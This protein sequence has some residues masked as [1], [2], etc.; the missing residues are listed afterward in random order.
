MNNLI[1]LKGKTGT[2]LSIFFVLALMLLPAQ[3]VAQSSGKLSGTATDAN[4]AAVHKANVVIT[5]QSTGTIYK[6]VTGDQGIYTFS[7][8]T[9]GTYNVTVTAPTFKQY[10]QDGVTV[11]VGVTATVN[12]KLEA[13]ESN[14]VVTVNADASQLQTD[15]SDIGVSLTCSSASE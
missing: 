10:S 14:Q 13:G 9:P 7:D 3:L 12:A 2:A 4:G 8:V 15:T 6:A 5:E 1:N 11:A